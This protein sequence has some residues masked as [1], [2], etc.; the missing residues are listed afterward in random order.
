M[1]LACRSIVKDKS[2]SSRLHK[3][4]LGADFVCQNPDVSI[5]ASYKLDKIPFRAIRHQN[6]KPIRST[7]HFLDFVEAIFTAARN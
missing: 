3:R 5:C 6:D 4:Q 2:N 7:G 1:H